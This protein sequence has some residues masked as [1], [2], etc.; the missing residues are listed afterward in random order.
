MGAALRREDGSTTQDPQLLR[1]KV[2]LPWQKGPGYSIESR[3]LKAQ[4]GLEYC[5]IP[6]F[7]EVAAPLKKCSDALPK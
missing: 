6:S 1:P 3:R 4:S 7:V 2:V 5:I